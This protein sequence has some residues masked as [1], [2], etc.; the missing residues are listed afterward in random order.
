VRCV[1]YTVV[2]IKNYTDCLVYS[3]YFTFGSYTPE[4]SDFQYVAPGIINA[5][6]VIVQSE[7]V[8][9]I[10]CTYGY[11]DTKFIVS[12][13]PKV[14]AIVNLNENNL[15]IPKEWK[16]K[17]CDKKVFLLNT[18]YSYFPASFSNKTKSG[19]Y[20]VRFHNEILE[21]IVDKKDVGLIWRPHPLLK[22]MIT[23]RFPEC[24]EY[25]QYF[26][27]T[28]LESSNCVI[29]NLEDYR[30]AFCYSDALISTWSS[31][32]NEYMVLGK[33]VMIFQTQLSEEARVRAPIDRGINYFRFGSN[34]ISFDEFVEMVKAGEDPL[35]ERR[36][37]MIKQAF[38][39]MNGNAGY[40]AYMNIK[41][42]V[43]L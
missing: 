38:V 2:K 11:E 12:G 8:K 21:A 20:G 6:R 22:N 28:L 25:I 16:E 4:K 30:P 15:Y 29:D 9:R 17:L 7:K 39:N 40:N 41:R 23:D 1:F 31:L 36:M 26:E 34:S 19:N 13:S 35:Y 32:I 10:F 14:D 3:P 27:K 43:L 5:D 18:H 37:E 33:P 24:L 42:E